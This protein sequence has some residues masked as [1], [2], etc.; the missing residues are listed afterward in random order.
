MAEQKK[1]ET[2]PTKPAEGG[3]D[4]GAGSAELSKK[5]KYQAQRGVTLPKI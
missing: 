3:D 2:R 5:G 1:K 4:G